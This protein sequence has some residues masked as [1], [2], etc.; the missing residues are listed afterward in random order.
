MT[1][2]PEDVKRARDMLGWGLLIMTIGIVRLTEGAIEFR[3]A[4][5]LFIL[6]IAAAHFWHPELTKDGRRSRAG[7]V[8][9][10]FVALWGM[11][12]VHH[13]YGLDYSTSWPLL[14]IG[15]GVMIVWRSVERP[16][17]GGTAPGGQP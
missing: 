10:L 12:T 5:P 16:G 17:D 1:T 3:T 14:L 7:A 15:G 2:T 4:W 6:T 8:F 13:L 11:V 9:L